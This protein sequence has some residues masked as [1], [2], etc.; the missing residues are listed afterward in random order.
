MFEVHTF[1]ARDGSGTGAS[2]H[3]DGANLPGGSIAWI[4]QA[5]LCPADMAASS[6][7]VGI[8]NAAEILA[9]VCRSGFCCVPNSK[10]DGNSAS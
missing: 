8:G 4:H 5:T 9:E 10:P 6:G 3:E 1:R 7:V 2:I